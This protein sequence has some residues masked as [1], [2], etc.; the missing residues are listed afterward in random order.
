MAAISVNRVLSG[1]VNYTVSS[2]TNP[3]AIT[4]GNTIDPAKS[5][6]TVTVR[7]SDNEGR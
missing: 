1:S 7:D 4:L 3:T 2:G 5:A 6:V